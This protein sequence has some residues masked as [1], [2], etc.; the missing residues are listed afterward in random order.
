MKLFKR[1]VQN[2]RTQQLV[3]LAYF[4][5]YSLTS[6]PFTCSVSHLKVGQEKSEVL[7]NP[8]IRLSRVDKQK[9]LKLQ[10][11]NGG[12]SGLGKTNFN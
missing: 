6:R 1:Y 2:L 9:I 10:I 4:F 3:F 7:F 12:C 11:E 5:L 8:K